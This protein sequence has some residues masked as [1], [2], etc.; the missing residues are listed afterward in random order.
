[1]T[2]LR[3]GIVGCGKIADQHVAAIRRIPFATV[4]AACDREEL[5]A[6]QLAER[7][8]IPYFSGDVDQMLVDAPSDVVHITTPPASHFSLAVRCLEAGS[9]VYVEKPFTLST[10][11]A[12]QL[13]SS[14][15]QRGLAVTAGHNL[16]Y[17]WENI[18]ARKLVRAGYLGGPPVHIESYYTYNFGDAH[19]ARG[20]LGDSHHWVRRLPGGLLQNIISHGIARIAEFMDTDS[21]SV[22]AFGYTSPLLSRIGEANII[23]E[24]RVHIHDERNTTASFVFSSQVSPPVNGY[25]LYGLRNSLVV[26]NVHHTMMRESS[27]DYKSYLNY[28]IPPVISAF[29]HLRNARRNMGRFMRSDFHDDSG[30]K[31]YIE[32]FYRAILEDAELPSSYREILLTSRIMDQ[33]FDQLGAQNTSLATVALT[34][35]SGVTV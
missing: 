3:V 19:Y 32:A 24:L 25:R 15:L 31:N 21:A 29:E 9:H 16:Q 20:V 6:E 30:L 10:G 34:E 2:R 28:F 4:V 8:A 7:H 35:L 26:D 11:E 14:A 33:I 5:M 13:V 1:V 22:S 12:E 23:D 27:A 18:E 17:T